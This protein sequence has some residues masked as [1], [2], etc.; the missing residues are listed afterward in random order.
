MQTEAMQSKLKKAFDSCQ[1]IESNLI[2]CEKQYQ[3]KPLAVYYFD[4]SNEIPKDERSLYDYQDK[5][6][7]KRYFESRKALQW[8]HYLVFVVD[9]D[10][11][12][13]EFNRLKPFI[14]GD[15]NFA[16]KFL[17]HEKEL[18]TFVMPRQKQ[19]IRKAKDE[20]VI[21]VWL[22][23]LD[24]NGL[25]DIYSDKKRKHVVDAV[26]ENWRNIA[27]I[28]K[29]AKKSRKL[30]TIN[31]QAREN[32]FLAKL[33]KNNYRD[34]PKGDVFEFG[35]VNL[36]YGANATGK[37]SLLEAVELFYSGSNQRSEVSS[38]Q[39]RPQIQFKGEKS[40]VTIDNSPSARRQRDLEWFGT[41][42]RG[43]D[44]LNSNF[45][46]YIFFNSDAAF[47]LEHS[48][49]NSDIAK[50]LARLALGEDVNTL[51]GQI[52]EYAVEFQR[53]YPR[54]ENDSRSVNEKITEIK[55]L[56]SQLKKSTVVVDVM[57]ER[58]VKNL[59]E[60][61][62]RRLPKGPDDVL[63]SFVDSILDLEAFAKVVTK[64]NWID[65]WTIEKIGENKKYYD[66]KKRELE[67]II[68]EEN[69]IQ[70]SEKEEKQ[71]KESTNK[72]H[73]ILMRLERYITANW[74]AKQRELHELDHIVSQSQEIE[75]ILESIDTNILTAEHGKN[76]LSNA[77][78][79]VK[80]KL[81]ENEIELKN[82]QE[83]LNK[84]QSDFTEIKASIVEIRAL[85]KHYLKSAPDATDCPLCG[86]H[87]SKA[88]L[89]QRVSRLLDLGS[90]EEKGA[91]EL[92]D[93]TAAIK[94]TIRE[95]KKMN[96][97]LQR[98]EELAGKLSLPKN[99]PISELL[100][101]TK[102]R[103][104]K[105][106]NKQS[107]LQ[108]LRSY[109]KRLTENG[110]SVEEYTDLLDELRGPADNQD[111]S[112]RMF[113]LA[114]WQKEQARV[115]QDLQRISAEVEKISAKRKQLLIGIKE[116]TKG[117]GR[118]AVSAD[119][120]VI[121]INDRISLISN[122]LERYRALHD[123]VQI[124]KVDSLNKIVR[125]IDVVA[126]LA[127]EFVKEKENEKKRSSQLQQATVDLSVLDKS[128][129]EAEGRLKRCETARSV[130]ETII[131]K[132]SIERVVTEFISRNQKRISEIF[133]SIHSPH[134]FVGL[135]HEKGEEDFSGELKLVKINN[136]KETRVSVSEISAGQRAA[137][138]LS[139]FLCLNEKVENAPPLIL[140]D[141]PVAH[142]DDMNALSFLDYLREV[143]LNK[144]RQIFFAT[145][146]DKLAALF[147][148]KFE[149]LGEE[150]KK[151]PL[152]R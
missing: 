82:N 20:D 19:L 146:D 152:M 45:N 109:I 119:E 31:E 80:K 125:E 71:K 128:R 142:V 138:A 22:D 86:A 83:I 135:D 54:L 74:E 33:K 15:R 11:H 35:A 133:T 121:T 53:R 73:D 64:L 34:Y 50:A 116:L 150:F 87:Y 129:V 113:N 55:N 40:F 79:N 105:L 126:E 16:R 23:I 3:G 107:Q 18:D 26:I 14:E 97:V 52:K 115:E 7:A 131:N 132:H 47:F 114:A 141:D 21:E 8:N 69:D 24:K 51:W 78:R 62:I 149:F 27:D 127:K 139:I 29:S 75:S 81:T 117:L 46:R 63:S 68:K 148:R 66:K 1:M 57:F 13:K 61:K 88:E 92:V 4:S 118:P 96:V 30:P 143:A 32:K 59:R 77:F 94:K 84:I 123:F 85:G 25:S 144:N 5:F 38:S 120:A 110:Y 28:P 145:A 134:E 2:L 104:K 91:K 108:A 70:L 49:E 58:L 76:S 140:F 43:K 100:E 95:L 9:D 93:K 137:L 106:D 39:P 101:E 56:A 130:L 102:S 12:D 67:G 48:E 124:D 72:R 17:V 65:E 147:E 10:F 122:C 36:I 98:L 111:Q 136:G 89:K 37:T 112:R 60:I 99:T 42:G 90:S 44:D 103:I 151:I 41:Y 6:L